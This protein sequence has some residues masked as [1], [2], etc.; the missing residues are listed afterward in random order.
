VN[1]DGLQI[2]W[3]HI[4]IRMGL[5]PPLHTVPI[6][7]LARLVCE[8]HEAPDGLLRHD[9]ELAW[10]QAS[11]DVGRIETDLLEQQVIR[12][13]ALRELQPTSTEVTH[14]IVYE[15]REDVRG[16][17]VVVPLWAFALG[18]EGWELIEIPGQYQVGLRGHAME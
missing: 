11:G 14:T 10:I 2:K 3:V 12:S 1:V 13:H 7:R 4:G 18:L 17:E 8:A 9:G 5:T 16:I 6:D 15:I